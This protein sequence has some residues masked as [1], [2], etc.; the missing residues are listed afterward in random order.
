MFGKSGVSV[1]QT[2]PVRWC[3]FERNGEGVF[4]SRFAFSIEVGSDMI[5]KRGVLS[6]VALYGL[7][8]SILGFRRGFPFGGFN[9]AP[10][11]KEASLGYYER[12]SERFV[13]LPNL[14][15]NFLQRPTEAGAGM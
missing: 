2:Y 10:L 14:P 13:V 1:C 5:C 9:V 7:P 15:P 4:Y 8:N 3:R 12:G 6:K 11:A